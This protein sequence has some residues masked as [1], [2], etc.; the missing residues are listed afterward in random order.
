MTKTIRK[1]AIIGS[2]FMGAQIVALAALHGYSVRV[3]DIEKEALEKAKDA[4]KLIID[5]YSSKKGCPG[6]TKQ[7][8]S[9]VSYCVDIANAVKDA[10]LIIEVVPENLELKQKLFSQLDELAPAS[11]IITSNSSSIPISRIA[12]GVKRKDKVANTHF[13]T[14]II[15]NYFVD[16]GG[17]IATTDETMDSIDAWLRSMGC[18]PLRVKK[19]CMGFVFNRI[20]HSVKRE[21]LASWA[22]GN[23]DFRDIDRAWMISYGTSAGPFAMMDA[24]GLDIVYDVEMEYYRD[25]KDPKDKP[26]D[27]IKAMIDRGELGRKSGRGFYDWSAPEFA[28][29]NFIKPR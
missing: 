21:C 6:D 2:G 22:N 7:T 16:I 9:K 24:I 8:S 17:G 15:K 18:L 27:A 5:E 25:S 12:T 1:V 11:A 10:D 26:P 19:E 29:P 20:W 13:Y 4:I 3:Y 23:A 14:P 28:K